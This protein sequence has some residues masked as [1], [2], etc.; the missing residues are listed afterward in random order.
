MTIPDIE[1]PKEVCLTI[2]SSV[3][4][5]ARRKS[6]LTPLLRQAQ[7]SELSLG[8]SHPVYVLSVPNAS[9]DETLAQAELVRWR[10]LIFR[11][12][13]AIACAEAVRSEQS[14]KEVWAFLRIGEGPVVQATAN[15]MHDAEQLPEVRDG[16]Y[17][18]R[19]LLVPSRSV[20]ALWLKDLQGNHNLL[21]PLQLQPGQHKL[22]HPCTEAQFFASLTKGDIRP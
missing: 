21:L 19:L 18:M 10:Y 22:S 1:P 5:L 3:R 9:S 15:A 17:Q 7:R 8:A 2:V 20:A 4:K 13:Q 6:F 12:E 14:G 16:S 11:A